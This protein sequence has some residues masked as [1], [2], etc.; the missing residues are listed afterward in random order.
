MIPDIKVIGPESA[1]Q[2]SISEKRDPSTLAKKQVGGAK[3]MNRPSIT[4]DDEKIDEEI[5]FGREKDF[6]E[7]E[8]QLEDETSTSGNYCIKQPNQLI[9]PERSLLA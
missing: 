9:N 6:E 1:F 4:F 5:I 8:F 3:I 7:D 2:V